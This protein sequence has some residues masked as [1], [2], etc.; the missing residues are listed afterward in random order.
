MMSGGCSFG[1]NVSLK[2]KKWSTCFLSWTNIIHY[3]T[4]AESFHAAATKQKAFSLHLRNSLKR[5]LA[6]SEAYSHLQISFETYKLVL[7]SK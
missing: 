1:A 5:R 4:N 6:I 3:S 2:L 7:E